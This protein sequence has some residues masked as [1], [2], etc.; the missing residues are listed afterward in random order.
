MISDPKLEFQEKFFDE[1]DNLNYNLTHKEM[2]VK[3]LVRLH[4]KNL[5]LFNTEYQ[6][7]EVWSL[8]KKRLLIDSILRKYDISMIFLRQNVKHDDL[9]FEC[10]D[11]QQRLRSIIQFIRNQFDLTPDVTPELEN[12]YFYDQLSPE[13]RTKIQSFNINSIHVANADDDT[14]TDI[15]MRLQEGVTLNHAEKLN[16]EKSKMRK[17]AIELSKHEFF[18]STLLPNLRFSYRYYAAQML[19]LS[20]DPQSSDVGYA[21]LKRKYDAYKHHFP[22]SIMAKTIKSLT[23]LQKILGARTHVIRSKSDILILHLISSKLLPTYSTRGF[24]DMIGRFI[25][26]FISRVVRVSQSANENS[27]SPY[28]RYAYH[29]KYASLRIQEK[30]NIMASQLLLAIP[31]MK[32]KDPRRSFSDP[33]RLA[34]YVRADGKCAKC[35]LNTNF[36]EGNVDHIIRHTDGGFTNIKNGRWVCQVCH[37][38]VIHGGKLR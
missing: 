6:R 31:E 18:R 33:E 29:K 10:I 12:R 4:N 20:T 14:I 23:F 21:P 8:K 7:M 3:D 24:E 38:K 34:I 9:R 11:G 15:F 19:A 2:K 26:D 27:K 25:I 28:V 30:Y 1:I 17:A 32:R 16:A 35:G 37:H 36:D 13:I 5:L 22:D